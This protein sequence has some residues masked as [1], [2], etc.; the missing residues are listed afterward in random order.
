MR[1][2]IHPEF[3]PAIAFSMIA[4]AV[5]LFVSGIDLLTTCQT[6]EI[7]GFPSTV[8]CSYPFQGYG[9]TFLL[10]AALLTILG[11]NI[12]VRYAA[13]RGWR[14]HGGPDPTTLS[15]FV[16]AGAIAVYLIVL[17]LVV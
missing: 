14:S 15:A 8:G 3:L 1:P 2:R 6:V 16:A 10:A 7:A 5:G 12:F 4:L 11:F 9:V 13:F 17:L